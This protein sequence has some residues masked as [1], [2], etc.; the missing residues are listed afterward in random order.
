MKNIPSLALPRGWYLAVLLSALVAGCGSGGR[1]PVLGVGGV[2]QRAPTVTAVTPVQNATGVR[3]DDP[4]ITATFSEPMSPIAGDA[5]FVLRCAAPCVN[6]TG[7]VSLD[8]SGRVATFRLTPGTTLAPLTTYTATIT[9]ARSQATGLP[10]DN[11]FTWMFTTGTRPRVSSTLPVTSSP[12]PT[13][14]IAV[15]TVISATFSE[16]M[17]PATLNAASFTVR[18]AAPCS[19]PAGTV[20]YDAATR[21]VSFTPAAALDAATTYTVT[22]T[23]A[24]TNLAGSALAGNQAAFPA[25]SN[26]VWSFTTQSPPTVTAV[27][28]VNGA[29]GVPIDNTVINAAFSEPVAPLTG[30]AS[31]TVTCAAPCSNP[32]G[33]VS[34]DASNRIATFTLTA[35]T[36]LEA[37]T[38]Y[39]ATVAGAQSLATGLRM[40][41]PFV[42]QFTTGVAPDTTRPRVTVTQPAT[43]SPGPTPN[44]P[45]NTAISAVFTE[46]MAPAT[47][48]ATSFT[49]T[50]AAPCTNPAGNVSYAVGT[51]MAVF[52]PAAVL[53]AGTTYTVTITTAATD[54]AGNALAGNQAPLP[55]ASNYVWQFTTTAAAPPA[56]ITVSSTNPAAGQTLVCPSASVNASFNVPS[57]LRLDPATVTTNTFT[58]TGPGPAFAPV[59]AS[60]VVL[61][62]ATGQIATFTPQNDLSSGMTF[63]ATVIGGANGV[64]DLAVPANQMLGNFSWSFMVGPATGNCLAP[65]ALR[66]AAPFGIIGGSAGMTNQGLQTIINGDIGTTAVSTA[67]T[68][69]HDAGPGCTYTETPLNNGTVNGGIFTAAPPPTPACPSEGNATTFAIATQARADALQ[70]YNDLVALPPGPDP[71]AGSLGNL[72]LTPGVYTSAAGPFSIQGG[73]LTLDAQGNANGVWVFQMATSLTVGGPG[74]AF[75]QRVVLVNGA[76]AKNVFWQVGS[77]ATLNAAGGGSFAGTVI[78]QSGAAVSTAGNTV[79][80]TIDGRVLSLGASVTL[81][82]TVINVPAP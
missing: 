70:A 46:D 80:V 59:A 7:T 29:T 32:T 50:C 13:P 78:A 15:G 1:D 67:V 51:R 39:T 37:L 48:N 77:A 17:A 38:R 33:T 68:G 49:V 36:R 82:D 40:A 54:L 62:G 10:L 56:N 4:S 22:V 74:A 11:P 42:W 25:A 20:S 61:D 8:A 27:A 35:G 57:G 71:G 16:D 28:P 72:V 21:T 43:T 2:A 44:V 23:T 73:D 63:I 55:A 34:L 79:I 47:L 58:L 45:A 14:G 18:C 65:V 9:G 64:R 19:A 60:S 75:P 66:S 6:P 3:L 53:D 52:T 31:F 69:F 41:A 12:G 30:G 5:S 26:Y 76:Q 81:V 24:A